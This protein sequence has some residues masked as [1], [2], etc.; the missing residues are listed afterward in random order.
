MERNA[1]DVAL[2]C[3]ADHLDPGMEGL[4]SAFSQPKVIHE[5]LSLA[6]ILKDVYI[7]NLHCQNLP[8]TSGNP[9]YAWCSGTL[10]ALSS[11]IHSHCRRQ[12]CRTH[13]AFPCGSQNPTAAHIPNYL[14]LIHTGILP[15]QLNYVTFLLYNAEEEIPNVKNEEIYEITKWFSL[16]NKI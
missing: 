14:E 5:G 11:T 6:R 4:Q 7:K 15:A 10:R 2:C 3:D 12:F 8:Q 16:K 13:D 9:A 1:K